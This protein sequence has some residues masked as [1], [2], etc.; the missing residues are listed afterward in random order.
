MPTT[1]TLHDRADIDGLRDLIRSVRAGDHA[2]F[3]ELVRLHQQYAYALAMR[4][5]WDHAEAEDI[6][7]DSF[8]RVWNHCGSYNE[9]MRF[10]TWLYSIVTRV[11]MDR[12]RRRRR[13][14]LLFVRSTGENDDVPEQSSI[15][16]GVHNAQAIERVRSL[17]AQL[18][19][20][21]RL[22]FTLRDLQDLPAEEVAQITGMSPSSI[23]ANLWHARKRMR[24][25]LGA[26]GIKEEG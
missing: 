1:T 10:T 22:V 7:Q 3:G 17:T 24:H 18:P 11:A 21:Q 25:L 23:K 13:W 16:H 5:V 9:E 20:V 8:I 4:F 15:E 14:G 19:H 26:Y 12:I 6:V 2:A